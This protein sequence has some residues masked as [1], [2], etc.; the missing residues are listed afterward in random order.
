MDDHPCATCLRWWEC[1][2]ADADRCP[3]IHREVTEHEKKA[4]R[5]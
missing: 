3:M 2:G 4:Q 5:L 1:N